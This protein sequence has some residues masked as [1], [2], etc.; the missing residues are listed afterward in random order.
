M[1]FEDETWWSRLARPAVHTWSERNHPLRLV[2]QRL[3]KDDPEAKALAC[4]GL[5]VSSP[6]DAA[7]DAERVWLRFVPDRPVSAATIQFLAWC[8]D[9]LQAAG[10]KALL[11]IWDNASWHVS[12]AVKTWFREHSREVKRTGQGVR[13]IPSYL[14]VKS[15]WLNPLEVRWMQAKRHVFEAEA[16]L[17]PQQLA[18]RVCDHFRCPYEDHLVIPE[19][20]S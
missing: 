19:N 13:V 15:P 14:P 12:A 10:K 8:C 11:L 2:E 4:Y 7:F 6:G 5:L 17:T 9:R 1:G 18:G 3:A 16:V 20:V